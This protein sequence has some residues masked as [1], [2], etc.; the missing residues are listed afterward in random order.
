M[1]VAG[2][3]Y[4]LRRGIDSPFDLVK[5]TAGVRSANDGGLEELPAQ[6]NVGGLLTLKS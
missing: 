5:K 3:I 6:S 2:A 1:M 4:A